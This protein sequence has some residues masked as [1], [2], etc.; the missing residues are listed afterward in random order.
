MCDGHLVDRLYE[1]Y[2]IKQRLRKFNVWYAG[3]D[4]HRRPGLDATSWH[5][6]VVVAGEW[7]SR[8]F[9][10]LSPFFS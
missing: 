1:I 8:I 6:I 3:G 5:A 7:L 10:E 4:K 9:T 2:D